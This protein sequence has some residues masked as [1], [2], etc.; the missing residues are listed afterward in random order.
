MATLNQRKAVKETIDNL[1]KG[2][3]VSIGK[4]LVK[5][6]YGKSMQ[7]N[8]QVV[9]K[10]KGWQEL[11][12]EYLPDSLLAKVHKDGLKATFTDK[13]NNDAPDLAVRHKYLETGYKIKGKMVEHTDLTSGGEPII[14]MPTEVIEKFKLNEIP[15]STSDNS[16]GQPQVQSN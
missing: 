1:R 6:G 3:K 13:F 15:S 12:E 16:E 7:T 14:F 5:N 8:P 11:M 4:I 9:T 10:S 2:K